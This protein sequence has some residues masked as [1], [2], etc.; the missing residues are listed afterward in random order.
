MATRS[1]RAFLVGAVVLIVVVCGGPRAIGEEVHQGVEGVEREPG[2]HEVRL[3]L[4]D[5]GR[6]VV[7]YLLGE[8][9]NSLRL[10]LPTGRSE[11]IRVEVP[12]GG[13][14][15]ADGVITSPRPQARFR[16]V[17]TADDPRAS[18]RAQY[19][20]AFH[21]ESGGMAVYLPY[22]LPEGDDAARVLVEGA[23]GT[24]AIVDGR[25]VAID[26]EYRIVDPSGF[27]LLGRSLRRGS[28]IQAPKDVPMWL[29]Q[30]IRQSYE[31]GQREVTS[32]LGVARKRIPVLVD[33]YIGEKVEVNNGGDAA[34]ASHCAV[35]L[36]F[37]GEAWR[38]RTR[39]MRTR[40]NDVLVHEL[41]HCYQSAGR[42]QRWAHEGHA[43]FLEVLLASRP[44]GKYLPG[45][46]AETRFVGDFDR[47]MNR[48]RTG[49]H[50]IDAYA[51]GS[52][53]YWLRWLETGRLN[54]LEQRAFEVNGSDVDTIARGFVNRSVTEKEITAFLRTAGVIVD[55][56]ER[57]RE[58]VSSVRSRLMMTLLRANCD[59]A[60]VGYWRKD[61]SIELDAPGCPEL[62]R[63]ELRTVAGH[64]VIDEVYLGYAAVGAACGEVGRVLL[65]GVNGKRRFV[66]CDRSHDW[67]STWRSRYRLVA[68][69]GESDGEKS[70]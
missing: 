62:D 3:L 10:G 16:I 59:H 45:S 61:R 43:R 41:V 67:P 1:N 63:L 2:H 64:D 12:V 55:V 38:H 66:D 29:K 5:D 69:L 33:W 30:S 27:V 34:G 60:N 47:C 36:W 68:P 28:M 4:G 48:L 7:E 40:M 35:R 18:F 57:V 14:V 21:V 24:V 9:V 58:G 56:T 31:E 22:L 52:V 8:V 53:V 20:V 19:P 46:S 39:E 70:K 17:V 13:E 25:Y 42:W 44:N 37:R 26:G 6:V 65:V 51:C 50:G 32:L 49:A 54:M 23:R 15:G 11:G